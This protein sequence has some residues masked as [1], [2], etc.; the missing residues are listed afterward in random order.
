[1]PLD[2]FPAGRVIWQVEV[3]PNDQM[4]YDTAGDYFMRDGVC[5]VQVAEDLPAAMGE[6]TYPNEHFLIALHEMVEWYLMQKRGI[7]EEEVSA[8][9]VAYE[10]EA[11]LT[12]HR[13]GEPGDQPD[14]PYRREHRE[15]SLI[16]FQVALMAG[17]IDYGKME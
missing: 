17:F 14:A 2:E 1:M 12:G 16:E 13:P 4:R 9:D 15:A 3:V 5:V 6:G 7:T 11:I 10:A 8:F